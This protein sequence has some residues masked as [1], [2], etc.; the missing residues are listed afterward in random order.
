MYNKIKSLIDNKKNLFI[1]GKAGTGKT[2]LLRE[3]SRDYDGSCI[4][5]APT[6]VSAINAGGVTIH[7]MFSLG[8]G[9]QEP[10]KDF[11]RDISSIRKRILKHI[12]FLIID[13]ISMVRCDVLDAI[14]RRLR[15]V[16]RRSKK[17][18]GGLQ[19]VMFGD[20]LQL[21]PVTTEDEKNVL[22]LYY[23]DFYF[24]NSK[25]WEQTYFNVIELTDVY[26][27]K[28]PTFLKLLSDIRKCDLTLESKEIIDK[29]II[30]SRK[31]V[32]ND[33]SI[34]LC[35]L[36]NVAS[37]IN[38][39]KLGKPTHI[40]LA[41][42]TGDFNE[43]NSIS[44]IELKLRVGARVMITKNDN[45]TNL[46]CN[47]TLGVVSEIENRFIRVLTD[48]NNSIVITP[49][50]VECYKY[51]IREENDELK[52]DKIVTGS[53]TQFPL[54]LAYAVTIHK[55]QGLTFDNVTLHINEIFQSG[56]LYTALSRCRTIEGITMDSKI[57]DKMLIK[58]NAI[59][60]FFRYINENNGIFGKELK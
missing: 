16:K 29:I 42:I 13:E 33:K 9:V 2:T 53:C 10:D 35:A 37:R 31:R 8:I 5:V 60:E 19:V 18:F 55:S 7:S 39:Q 4:I 30:D 41:N 11:E 15:K 17:P 49:E 12:K 44:D 28:D 58:N 36:K 3:L 52:V 26:R 51:I 14:D 48:D 43:K 47:G 40:F 22:K 20:L 59:D 57:T 38:S 24:F 6:G 56:Q 34:N 27:Q 23:N 21:P 45:K 32:T 1:T 54:T 25:V 50:R 46:Y